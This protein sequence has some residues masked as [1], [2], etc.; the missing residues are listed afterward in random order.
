MAVAAVEEVD[1]IAIMEA[2]VEITAAEVAVPA[3]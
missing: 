1:G 2:S 3:P